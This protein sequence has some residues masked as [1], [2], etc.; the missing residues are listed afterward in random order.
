MCDRNPFLCSYCDRVLL[1]SSPF[2]DAATIGVNLE[3]I[4]FNCLNF[5]PFITLIKR[6]KSI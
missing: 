5:H 3:D 6:K 2:K 4:L 1:I